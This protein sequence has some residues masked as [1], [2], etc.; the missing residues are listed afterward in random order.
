MRLRS[1]TKNRSTPRVAV[2][3]PRGVMLIN[4]LWKRSNFVFSLKPF[5]TSVQADFRHSARS[6]LDPCSNSV[7]G[8]RK[9]KSDTPHKRYRISS[10]KYSWPS[11]ITDFK[12]L[13]WIRRCPVVL[14]SIV[15][16]SRKAGYTNL[17]K[18]KKATVPREVLFSSPDR[19]WS[20]EIN[21]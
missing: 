18:I 5:I 10:Y 9:N 20:R 12:Y 3:N 16:R 4:L 6:D 1:P 21:I 8:A 14:K 17:Q 2:V 13:F 19:V 11:I 7:R 15:N